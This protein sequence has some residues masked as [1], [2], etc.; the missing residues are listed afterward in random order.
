VLGVDSVPTRTTVRSGPF[1]AEAVV[2]GAVPAWLRGRLVR[3]APAIFSEQ[4]WHARHW[5]DGLGMLY[6]FEIGADGV[7]VW[8]QRLLD[9]DTARAATRGAVPFAQ[10]GTPNGRTVLKRALQP[11]PTSTDNANVSIVPLGDRWLAM[12]ETDRQLLVDPETLRVIGHAEYRDALPATMWMTAHPQLDRRR[13]SLVN[14]GTAVG[15]R[16]SLVV[17]EQAEGSMQRRALGHWSPRRL[18][19]VRRERDGTG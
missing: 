9:S 11:I 8:R 18:V 7:I 10:F 19:L 12:S 2:R 14:V 17:Y 13:R 6:A 1:E 3:T 4:G 15:L 5:F 16:S